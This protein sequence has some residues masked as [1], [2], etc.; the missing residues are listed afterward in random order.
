MS[1]DHETPL[2]ITQW[3]FQFILEKCVCAD[4]KESGD[5][6]RQCGSWC[7]LAGFDFTQITMCFVPQLFRELSQCK[8]AA[9]SKSSQFLA[10]SG[11]IRVVNG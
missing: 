10:E 5:F 6:E 9:D 3:Q 11:K 7:L 1:L 2:F 4:P 8:V